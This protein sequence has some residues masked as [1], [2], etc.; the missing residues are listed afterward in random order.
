MKLQHFFLLLLAISA[1]TLA[2][3]SAY[4]G[5]SHHD[6][7][8][9]ALPSPQ[10]S[11]PARSRFKL[12]KIFNFEYYKKVFKKAY[13]SIIEELFRK[14]LVLPRAFRAAI[15]AFSYKCCGSSF[16]LALNTYSDSSD[17]ELDQMKNKMLE[18]GSENK[19][20]NATG[21]EPKMSN[22]TDSRP[23]VNPNDIEENLAKL[24][25]DDV[26]DDFALAR[27][28]AEL[29]DLATSEENDSMSQR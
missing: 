15:S 21:I 13:S 19:T 28:R 16:F 26:D 23:E 10:K 27:I 2:L 24:A 8:K 17:E 3:C 9:I 6:K 14:K 22:K 4:S 18:H 5:D 1:T 25:A 20:I 7:P 29:D 11:L 12:P